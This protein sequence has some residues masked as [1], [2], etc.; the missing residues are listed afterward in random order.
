[1]PSLNILADTFVNFI[2][3]PKK[4]GPGKSLIQIFNNEIHYQKHVEEVY[5]MLLSNP[6]RGQKF[7]V[8]FAY[9]ESG[10]IL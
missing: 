8:F 2:L 9:L 3:V 5:Y 6:T 10:R 4:F 1:M 7:K